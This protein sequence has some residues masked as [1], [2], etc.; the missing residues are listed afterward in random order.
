[1]GRRSRVGAGGRGD[2][3]RHGEHHC[4]LPRDPGRGL[5]GSADSRRGRDRCGPGLR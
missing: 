2:R 4:L 1:M 5:P 3:D